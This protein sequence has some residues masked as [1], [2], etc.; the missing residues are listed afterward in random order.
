[1]GMAVKIENREAY[2]RVPQLLL[3]AMR[4]RNPAF[5][6]A[7]GDLGVEIGF[8][9]IPSA[10]ERILRLCREAG[11]PS[12][13]AT[14]ILSTM[15]EEGV[16]ARAELIDAAAAGEADCVMLHGGPNIC[17]AVRFLGELLERRNT[18]KGDR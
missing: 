10:Q 1:M 11:M 9:A 12:V 16:P 15:V 13:I 14:G 3:Q 5:L 17:A 18:T 6:V 8:G 7:R 2:R 4:S